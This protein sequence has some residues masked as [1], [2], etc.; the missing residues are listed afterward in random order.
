ME[1]VEVTTEV[2][3]AGAHHI[4]QVRGGRDDGGG[5]VVTKPDGRVRLL[6]RL[7]GQINYNI[8]RVF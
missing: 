2:D 5:G 8:V 3:E 4:L 6:G 1:I 7:W